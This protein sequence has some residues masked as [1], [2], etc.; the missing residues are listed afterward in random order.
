M[1]S[2]LARRIARLSVW[3]ELSSR[4][5]HDDSRPPQG[6]VHEFQ[7][8]IIEQFSRFQSHLPDVLRGEPRI[9]QKAEDPFVPRHGAAIPPMPEGEITLLPDCERP[10]GEPQW[11]EGNRAMRV[12]VSRKEDSWRN[13]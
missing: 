11:D 5:L 9:G 7:P 13:E 12:F 1:L 2:A 6:G 8:F 4:C 10:R 3:T